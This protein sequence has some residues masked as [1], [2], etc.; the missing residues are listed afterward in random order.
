M[1]RPVSPKLEARNPIP[2]RR[3]KNL[4]IETNSLESPLFSDLLQT[5]CFGYLDFHF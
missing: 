5:S 3:D 2:A 4:M 1:D